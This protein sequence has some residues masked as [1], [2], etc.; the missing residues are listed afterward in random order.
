MSHIKNSP[1]CLTSPGKRRV[2]RDRQDKTAPENKLTTPIHCEKDL[3]NWVNLPTSA[4]YAAAG[5]NR[6]LMT[7]ARDTVLK[8]TSWSSAGTHA[9][10]VRHYGIQRSKNSNRIGERGPMRSRSNTDAQKQAEPTFKS[11]S[12]TQKNTSPESWRIQTKERRNCSS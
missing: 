4:K 7:S 2:N 12:L 1:K 11:K 9:G 8:M 10:T 6:W 5:P 3:Q